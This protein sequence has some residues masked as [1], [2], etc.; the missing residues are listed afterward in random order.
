MK[1]LCLFFLLILLSSCSSIDDSI[2]SSHKESDEEP[3]QNQTSIPTL[4]DVY[5]RDFS[6]D[7][8]LHSSTLGDIHYNIMV[9]SGYNEKSLTLY[10]SLFLV[11]KD[12]IDLE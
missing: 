12:F 8:V 6:L 11:I 2:D 5:Y 9:P 3:P 1:R 4:N 7:N 10:F